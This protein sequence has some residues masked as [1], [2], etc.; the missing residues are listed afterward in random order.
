MQQISLN[1]I[2][3][4]I[5]SLVLFL[6]TLAINFTVDLSLKSFTQAIL[7]N[8]SLVLIAHL[9]LRKITFEFLFNSFIVLFIFSRP[10]SGVIFSDETL[11]ST[12]NTYGVIEVDND[13]TKSILATYCAIIH[14]SFLVGILFR[15]NY[16]K[17]SFKLRFLDKPT[18]HQINFVNNFLIIILFIL[19][20]PIQISYINFIFTNGY[21]A[22][23]NSEDFTGLVYKD[24][25][26]RALYL[27]LPI[28]FIYQIKV[29][30]IISKNLLILITLFIFL[31]I[32]TGQRGHAVLLAVS[33]YLFYSVS[34]NKNIAIYKIITYG[35]FALA[36]LVIVDILRSSDSSDSILLLTLQGFGTTLNT[37]QAGFYFLENLR[38]MQDSS[39]SLYGLTDYIERIL[40]P[41]L[42]KIYNNRSHDLLVT[43]DYLGHKLTYLMNKDTWLLGYGMGSAFFLE[44]YIDFGLFSSLLILTMILILYKL[45]EY[46]VRFSV[47]FLSSLVF[48]NLTQYLLFLPRGSLSNFFPTLIF[49][50]FFYF[51]IYTLAITS[52]YF[53]T[54][55]NHKL[56]KNAA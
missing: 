42:E 23:F 13:I 36:F 52:F 4:F 16:M 8:I 54:K 46:R 56:S 19:F 12:I 35:F 29:K 3:F 47:G 31:E 5:L 15:S 7:F 53:F 18:N 44:L 55:I 26:S 17:L 30:Q 2:S 40:N 45:F 48:I 33:L 38:D 51:I 20:I 10:I 28:A 24:L 6:S 32:L 25:I 49:T 21:L 43:S 50:F 11:F 37:H 34:L 22:L 1:Y 41:G 39:Y 14:I 9:F 27:S